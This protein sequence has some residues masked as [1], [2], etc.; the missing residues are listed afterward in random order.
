MGIR[1]SSVGQLGGGVSVCLRTVAGFDWGGSWTNFAMAI[2]KALWGRK[3]YGHAHITN[4]TACHTTTTAL[5]LPWLMQ[6]HKHAQ[7][8]VRWCV[9]PRLHWRACSYQFTTHP[10]T[11][12]R[13]Q[14]HAN[15]RY[16]VMP[17]EWDQVMPNLE[18]LIQNGKVQGSWPVARDQWGLYAN[19]LETVLLVEIPAEEYRSAD[20]IV[21]GR[22]DV[23]IIQQSSCV[24]GKLLDDW[25][26]G[27]YYSNTH[28]KACLVLKPPASSSTTTEGSQ[29][30][31]CTTDYD[32]L[33]GMINVQVTAINNN[34]HVSDQLDR[35]VFPPNVML[36]TA[37]IAKPVK[38]N[39]VAVHRMI[40]RDLGSKKHWLEDV[41]RFK[42]TE[43]AAGVE[44]INKQLI[45]AYTLAFVFASREYAEKAC[46]NMGLIATNSNGTH[47]LTFSLRSPADLAWQR[48]AGG[49]FRQTVAMLM[50]MALE[51]VQTVIICAIPTQ[52]I[53]AAGQATSEKFVITER[54]EDLKLLLP[55]PDSTD[56]VYSCAHIAKIYA[57][58]PSALVEARRKLADV[59]TRANG[60]EDDDASE[61]ERIIERLIVE[62][63]QE[64]ASAAEST[65]S[66]T[67]MVQQ[68]PVAFSIPWRMTCVLRTG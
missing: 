28:I 42:P 67:H 37:V 18:T 43:M 5:A 22:D 54:A 65:S 25:D 56:A 48:N 23:Y 58:E 27:R 31:Q 63:A 29:R 3:W 68:L 36:Y 53:Q 39:A 52:V 6:A 32:R 10:H 64:T 61:L 60:S 40:E 38:E 7:T 33:G 9:H 30:V 20:R 14:R 21:P 12:A 1:A 35:S 24:E 19:K 11:P 15:C 34:V 45:H 51:D 57:L 62:M 44:A 46:H 16:E 66:S 49:Y 2:G 50:D 47:S 55:V 59:R 13:K 26:Q 41:S 17:G 8:C 4:T